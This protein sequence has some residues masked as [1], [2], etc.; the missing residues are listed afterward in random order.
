MKIFIHIFIISSFCIYIFQSYDIQRVESYEIFSFNLENYNRIFEFNST[1]YFQNEKSYINIVQRKYDNDN[2]INLYIYYD[3]SKIKVKYTDVQNYDKV[4]YLV[5]YKGKIIQ[6]DLN[7]TNPFIYLVFKS[8]NKNS[9]IFKFQIFNSNSY[10]NIPNSY[11]KFDSYQI[12]QKL[13]YVF[14]FSFNTNTEDDYIYYKNIINSGTVN[15]TIMDINKNILY[16]TNELQK[17]ISLKKHIK[18]GINLFF[19]RM[20]ITSQTYN[21]EIN[22]YNDST[23]YDIYEKLD[24]EKYLLNISIT[25]FSEY[26]IYVDTTKIYNNI[27]YFT[28]SPN[29]LISKSIYYYFF[30]TFDIDQIK[31]EISKRNYDMSNYPN[32]Y[33]TYTASI[34]NDTKC[35]I[36]K[37]SPN[38]NYTNFYFKVLYHDWI[39]IFSSFYDRSFN[40]LNRQYIIIKYQSSIYFNKLENAIISVMVDNGDDDCYVNL[41]SELN[42][43]YLED[44]RNNSGNL[45]NR[46]YINFNYFNGDK[47][48]LISNFKNNWNNYKLKIIN[49]KEYYNM[50]KEINSYHNFSSSFKFNKTFNQILTLLFSSNEKNYK[51][52][53][54][55]K[56]YPS[57][58]TLKINSFTE[59]ET[60]K[61]DG[62]KCYKTIYKNMFFDLIV[63]NK[64][65]FDEFQ[66]LVQYKNAT[67][68]ESKKYV[69]IISISVSVILLIIIVIIMVLFYMKKRKKNDYKTQLN[70]NPN[71]QLYKFE[72]NIDFYYIPGDIYKNK[73]YAT[74]YK[75]NGI[76]QENNQYTSY[77]ENNKQSLELNNVKYQKPTGSINET[78]EEDYNYSLFG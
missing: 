57:N 33:N 67:I 40:S 34:S 13:S 43:I 46:N 5:N 24:R 48:L 28:L 73:D 18:N 70:G 23:K 38:I 22:I 51:Y 31:L 10:T 27:L 64:E 72:R 26:F 50:T 61:P 58:L 65:E 19:I 62:D 56:I 49:N 17:Y 35:M 53:L 12:S 15:T 32:S 47:Y 75:M 7:I 63:S 54:N 14:S 16:E 74:P 55:F 59:N 25:N 20:R 1:N 8:Q 39:Y 45:I 41:Y 52:C 37:F 36:I 68:N 66:F 71:A 76:N 42:D 69:I 60:I 4:F 3:I 77:G 30:K 11:F 78:K 9:N 21:F 6:L 2:D 29:S 44:I